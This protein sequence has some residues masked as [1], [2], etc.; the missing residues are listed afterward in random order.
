MDHCEFFG[1]R[2]YSGNAI[3]LGDP[4]AVF[5]QAGPG[6]ANHC[7]FS[8]NPGRIPSS[9]LHPV[10]AVFLGASAGPLTH[11][12]FEYTSY[13][14]ISAPNGADVTHCCLSQPFP[15]IGNFV[16]NPGL[17]SRVGYDANLLANSHCIDAGDPNGPLD[18]DGSVADLGARV[19]DPGY[20]P[21]PYLAC[22]VTV[23][24]NCSVEAPTSML[25]SLSGSGVG[26]AILR[27][28]GLGLPAAG[29]LFIGLNPGLTFSGL[30]GDLCIDA[31]KRIGGM[32]STSYSAT[33]SGVLDLELPS[34]DVMGMAGTFVYLQGAI[35]VNNLVQATNAYEL[36]IRP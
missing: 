8:R 15:G 23:V 32:V 10:H 26:R 6:Q 4:L 19:F 11:S 14:Y 34:V 2:A 30:M 5:P 35:F 27:V 33:C 3:Y 9:N 18:P 1:N 17:V 31:P 29:Y 22:A 20:Y 16:A 28:E 13:T 7:T 12:L 24:T 21:E 25:G 36:L